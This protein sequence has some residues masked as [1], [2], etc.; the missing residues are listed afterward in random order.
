M[1]GVAGV[2]LVP[3]NSSH[4]HHASQEVVEIVLRAQSGDIDALLWLKEKS[5]PLR[6]S[7]AYKLCGCRKYLIDD[8][9]AEA[10]IGVMDALKMYKVNR[11]AHFFTYAYKFM[12][13]AVRKMRDRYAH[14]VRRPTAHYRDANALTYA[15]ATQSGFSAS[16]DHEKIKKQLG[17]GDMRHKMAVEAL[18]FDQSLQQPL[19][20]NEELTLEEILA[21]ESNGDCFGHDDRMYLMKKC[22]H[23][24]LDLRERHIVEMKFG[25]NADFPMTLEEIA[26]RYSLTRERV[27]QILRKT[28]KKIRQ[29]IRY[30][31]ACMKLGKDIAS[32]ARCAGI[33]EDG[34]YEKEIIINP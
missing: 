7:V 28:V 10:W 32:I 27:R 6:E 17:F 23:D 2:G 31:L 33:M 12:M 4:A 9:I 5:H 21:D 3:D 29:N 30:E 22:L 13:G 26:Q 18:Y 14:V 15:C 19:S 20:S 25:L 34:K 24:Y 1:E 11:N 8:A 16:V